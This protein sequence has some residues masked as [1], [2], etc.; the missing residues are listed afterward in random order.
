MNSTSQPR[1]SLNKYKRE[2]YNSMIFLR[3]LQRSIKDISHLSW[4]RNCLASSSL[5]TCMKQ[6][7][8][9]S[10]SFSSPLNSRPVASHTRDECNNHLVHMSDTV[11]VLMNPI[12]PIAAKC[13]RK[14][15]FVYKPLQ[16]HYSSAYGKS[17]KSQKLHSFYSFFVT[18]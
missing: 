9:T 15:I 16:N 2:T 5:L 1:E 6:A 12:H 4:L 8:A 10:S 17:S 13:A 7:A 11:S 18:F 14:Y 3:P